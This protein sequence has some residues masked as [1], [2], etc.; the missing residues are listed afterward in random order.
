MV[1]WGETQ[2]D[3]YLWTGRETAEE[4]K[5]LSAQFC[6][7]FVPPRAVSFVHA[8]IIMNMQQSLSLYLFV[9]ICMHMCHGRCVVVRGWDGLQFFPSAIGFELGSPG[10]VAAPLLTGSSHLPVCH[11][12]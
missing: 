1:Y 7:F 9:L 10:L 4:I 12:I 6:G 8:C 2:N 5:I 3:S 11:I